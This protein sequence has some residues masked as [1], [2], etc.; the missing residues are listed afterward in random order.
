MRQLST[1]G[2]QM[3][4]VFREIVMDYNG[5]TYTVA[6]TNR[7][8]RRIE[9]EGV[10]LFGTISRMARGAEKGDIPVF[11]LACIA[12]GFLREAGATVDE[13]EMIKDFLDDMAN[14]DARNVLSMFEQ[15]ALAISSPDEDQKKADAL[16]SPK[17]QARRAKS[18]K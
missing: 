8:L 7:M 13:D 18:G 2:Q 14:N 17:K 5:R 11:D 15:I 4:G 16:P 9:S 12:S 3:P 6:P 10:S 1:G